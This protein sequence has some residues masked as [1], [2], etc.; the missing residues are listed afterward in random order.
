MSNATP[1][2]GDIGAIASRRVEVP[3][4]ARIS[5]AQYPPEHHNTGMRI[6]I[7]ELMPS[8]RQ[9]PG[10]RGCYL[11]ADG[12]PG[13]G[14]AV[15]LWE[16]EEAADSS[17]AQRDVRAAHVKLA[18]LGLRLNSRKFYEVVAHDAPSPEPAETPALGS[19]PH[20]VYALPE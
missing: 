7:D 14:L 15:V 12:K 18:A 19:P 10:Y 2:G 3:M 9:A 16:T 4:F 5:H 8:L 17:S 13:T 6:L 20:C 11:L 1:Y